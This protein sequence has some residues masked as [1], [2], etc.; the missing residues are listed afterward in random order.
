[1]ATPPGETPSREEARKALGIS[2]KGPILLFFGMLR[3]DKGVEILIEAMG[4]I[5]EDC[6]L[7]LAGKPFDWDQNGVQEMIRRAG[8]NGKIIAHL[9]YIEEEKIPDYFAA[10]DAL[11][12]PYRKHYLGAAGPLKTAFGFG[13]P[14]IASRVHELDY[15]LNQSP[16]G[17]GTSPDSRDSLEDGIRRFLN[18]SGNEKKSMSENSRSLAGECTWKVLAGEYLKIYRTATLDPKGR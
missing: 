1:G 16:I 8:G 17:I 2:F 12:L 11:I 7:L 5:H 15:F 6:R 10:A 9:D 14:V 3:K 18:L 4:R 13:L